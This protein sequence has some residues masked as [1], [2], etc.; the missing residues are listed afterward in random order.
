L[1]IAIEPLLWKAIIC[2]SGLRS[3]NLRTISMTKL[4]QGN[5]ACEEIPVDTEAEARAGGPAAIAIAASR[6]GKQARPLEDAPAEFVMPA[7]ETAAG[8]G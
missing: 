2:T 7:G 1:Q 3:F 8:S 4:W 5:K 6:N